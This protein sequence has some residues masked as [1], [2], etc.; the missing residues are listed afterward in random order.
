MSE[1]LAPNGGYQASCQTWQMNTD[2]MGVYGDCYLK[3]AIIAMVG[4]GANQPEDAIY[5]LCIADA[6]G[7]P[8][9]GGRNYLL[10]FNNSELP[11]PARS[12]R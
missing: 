7:K 10:H 11:P 5:P 9:Q 4:L 8:L 3:R 12:G 2:T 1:S 6:S